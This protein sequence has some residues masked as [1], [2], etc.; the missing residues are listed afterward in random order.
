VSLAEDLRGDVNAVL[1][2]PDF[3]RDITLRRAVP[4]AYD[5]LTGV[6]GAE[7]V[8]TYASRGLLLDYRDSLV[9]GQVAS[10]GTSIRRGD[11]K[12]IFKVVTDLVPR[13]G[14]RLTV[15]ATTYT[16]VNDVRTVS[17]GSEGTP[18][19]YILQLRV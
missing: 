11:R 5:P 7:T 9:N 3:G 6:T 18:I 19:I 2:D 4:G 8:T 10:G 1:D 15:G 17:L 16:I 14:D 12:C 13:P